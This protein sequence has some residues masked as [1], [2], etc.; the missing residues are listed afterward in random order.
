MPAATSPSSRWWGAWPDFGAFAFGLGLAWWLRWSTTDLVWSLWLS[1]LVVGFAMILWQLSEPLRELIRGM[2][3]DKS[4]TGA[5]PK[6]ITAAV[7]AIGTLFGVAF[8]TIHFGGFHFVHSIFLNVFFPITGAPASGLAD[9]ALY[10][11]V[12]RRYAWFLPAAFVAER[13]AFR[14]SYRDPDTAVTPEAI[15]ARKARGDSMMLPYKNVIRMH[16]LIFFFAAAHFARIDNFAVYA[17]VSA[18]YFFPWRR[19]HGSS[20]TPAKSDAG[21]SSAVS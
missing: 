15:R 5:V 18:V 1:S 7:F 6:I 4:G 10:A 11:E 8:F 12:A 3:A 14:R 20:A 16:L 2:A 21:G 17:V 13:G 9:P 19:L